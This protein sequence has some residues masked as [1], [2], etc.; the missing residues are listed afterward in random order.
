MTG[1]QLILRALFSEGQMLKD[2]KEV[3]TAILLKKIVEI[4]TAILRAQP[5]TRMYG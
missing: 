5:H 2:L 1:Q 4:S 3:T